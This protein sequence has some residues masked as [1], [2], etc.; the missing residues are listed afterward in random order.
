MVLSVSV[1]HKHNGC[2]SYPYDELIQLVCCLPDLSLPVGS[3]LQEQQ[4][5]FAV[6]RAQGIPLRYTHCMAS[7][8]PQ[9]EFAYAEQLV[10]LAAGQQPGV[11]DNEQHLQEQHQQHLQTQ[12]QQPKLVSFPGW[13]KALA[14]AIAGDILGRPDTFRWV[15]ACCPKSLLSRHAVQR[16]CLCSAQ[17]CAGFSSAHMGMHASHM[18]AQCGACWRLNSL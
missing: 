7:F 12:L 17:T 4:Q 1:P 2:C 9:D 10:Q 13:L 18:S 15:A 14:K 11:Q 8:M 3:P 6:M 5:L 16:E